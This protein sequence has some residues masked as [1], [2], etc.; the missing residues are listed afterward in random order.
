MP[1]T[2]RR[3]ILAKVKSLREADLLPFHEM[4]DADMVNSA[5]GGRGGHIQRSH[6]HP[7]RDP[8][9]VP[10]PGARPRSLM[11]RRGRAV[12]RLAGDQRSQ[13]L[14]ARDRQL[15]R[16]TP[17]ATLGSH[18][19]PG[20][21]DR[22]G[23]RRWRRDTWLWKG[24]RVSLVDGTTVS[25]PDTPG[26]QKAFPQSTA[27]GIGLGFPLARMVAIISLA[28]GVA[29]DLALGPYKGKETGEPALFRTLLEPWRRGKSWWETAVLPRF[30]CSRS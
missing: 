17:A 24:R 26:N 28:T 2:T 13:A 11:S 4:L 25:M 19:P 29:R 5:A 7:V 14:R 16:R 9:P 18:R 10:L 20:P 21:P 12:D 3:W 1:Q 27:Q 23:D 8:L 22:A 30:S 6:L 15:L